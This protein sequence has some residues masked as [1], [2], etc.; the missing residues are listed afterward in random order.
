LDNGITILT[1]DV[2]VPK[3]MLLY[4]ETAVLNFSLLKL[5]NMKLAAKLHSHPTLLPDLGND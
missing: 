4:R 3:T 2:P 5:T 1:S